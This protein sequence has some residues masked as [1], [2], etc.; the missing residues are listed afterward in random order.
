M[1][2]LFFCTICART[3]LAGITGVPEGGSSHTTTPELVGVLAHVRIVRRHQ[4]HMAAHRRQRRRCRQERR[5]KEADRL[6]TRTARSMRAARL[7][8]ICNAQ[9]IMIVQTISHTQIRRPHLPALQAHNHVRRDAVHQVAEIALIL[10]DVSIPR[11]EF[12]S[13]CCPPYT[14]Q[15]RRDVIGTR[16]CAQPPVLW[17]AVTGRRFALVRLDHK[18]LRQRA[19]RSD[20]L[21]M[22]EHSRKL[23]SSKSAGG[24]SR[25]SRSP[26][27]RGFR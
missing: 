9:I 27:E 19:Q 23:Q 7:K 24:T 20:V 14:S 13:A 6:L 18:S 1:K 4:L 10:R 3:A 16:I 21:A 22:K 17:T 11:S 26:R 12:R 5:G 2:V 8:Q 25:T 15:A